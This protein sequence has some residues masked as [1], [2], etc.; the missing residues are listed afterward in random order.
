M[1]SQVR[2]QC[3]IF[4]L[5]IINIY[6]VNF[7]SCNLSLVRKTV[8]LVRRAEHAGMSWI[9]VHGRTTKQRTEPVNIEAIKLVKES[10]SVPVIANGDVKTLD[11]IRAVVESTN[12][13]GVMAARGILQNPAMYDGFTSTPL[14]CVQD[15]VDISLRCGLTF[16]C[17]H[18]HLMYM[19]EKVM[20]KT[21]RR[22]FNTLTS[23]PA[24]LD[25]L[26]E[27]Y[28]I[29]N[30]T[31]TWINNIILVLISNLFFSS[32]TWMMALINWLF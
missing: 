24:V 23:T 28:G 29:Q 17:F 32:L 27:Y 16:T 19:L 4:G 11:D 30:T 8:E 18:H 22:V 13:N 6:S 21:E 31:L 3:F 5:L 10:V 25:F 1:T 9:T 14:Q 12:V 2:D 15:W 26:N 20:A 7:S